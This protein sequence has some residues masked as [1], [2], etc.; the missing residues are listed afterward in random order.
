MAHQ[1][2]P[3]KITTDAE[4]V[5]EKPCDVVAM[6]GYLA[7]DHEDEHYRLY[8]DH[9]F[10]RWISIGP[11]IIKARSP[12]QDVHKIGQS[13]V[14]LDSEET[15]ILCQEA[16]VRAYQPQPGAAIGSGYEDVASQYPKT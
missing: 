5:L 6:V 4:A 13:V 9:D 2:E 14:W 12:S 10:R 11:G 3:D 7:A 1:F 8:Q 15:I 16:P